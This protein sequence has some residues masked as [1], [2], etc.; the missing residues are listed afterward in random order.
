MCLPVDSAVK[1]ASPPPLTHL[2]MPQNEVM[3]VAPMD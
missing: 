3:T 1:T 2:Y